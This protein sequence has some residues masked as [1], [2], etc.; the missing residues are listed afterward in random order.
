MRIDVHDR[1]G[2]PRIRI[3][4][5]PANPP[6]VV[7]TAEPESTA[8]ALVWNQATDDRGQ[9]RRCPVCGHGELFVRRAIPQVT[10]FAVVVGLG[11]AA[12]LF[13]YGKAL[14]TPALIALALLLVADVLIWR[15]APRTIVCYRCDAR[16]SQTP[17]PQ[18][19]KPWDPTKATT[20]EAPR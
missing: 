19:L 8:I 9:L 16:F 7:R 12:V 14:S 13:T 18:G 4:V 5:D 6:S 11:L 15:Y 20:R 10:W 2:R 1:R 17:I 3:R